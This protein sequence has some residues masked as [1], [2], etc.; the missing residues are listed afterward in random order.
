MSGP[1]GDCSPRLGP[2]R[3]SRP[4]WC[5]PRAGFRPR[6]WAQGSRR[7]QR[8]QGFLRARSPSPP[9]QPTCSLAR[10]R[11]GEA[12]SPCQGQEPQGHVAAAGTGQGLRGTRPPSYGPSSSGSLRRSG[13]WEPGGLRSGVAGLGTLQFESGITF[14]F[15]QTLTSGSWA[16][17]SMWRSV[18]QNVVQWIS[19]GSSAFIRIYFN[20]CQLL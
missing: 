16:C 8:L 9:P 3:D 4:D 6:R 2:L 10:L 17:S 1:L 11:R 18:T 12:D 19:K 20:I 13:G 7:G 5:P 15:G 14:S